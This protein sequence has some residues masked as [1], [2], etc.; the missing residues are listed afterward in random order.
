MA[1]KKTFSDKELK[2]ILL[3]ELG[4]RKSLEEI[5][6]EVARIDREELVNLVKNMRFEDALKQLN[7]INLQTIVTKVNDEVLGVNMA[8]DVNFKSISTTI[9]STDNNR[10][11]V[12]EFVDVWI[13][14]ISAPILEGV[15]P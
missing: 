10:C 5:A 11:E 3:A 15:T 13:D 4:V 2:A 1:K 9:F 14:E 6:M 8:F 12:Y 7:G